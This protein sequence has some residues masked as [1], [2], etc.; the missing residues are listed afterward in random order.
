MHLCLSY[1]LPCN[2]SSP[3]HL[4]APLWFLHQSLLDVWRSSRSVHWQHSSYTS[5]Q[6][7]PYVWLPFP[8]LLF[9]PVAKH[10]EWRSPL[11][12]LVP[13]PRGLI[14]VRSRPGL[15]ATVVWT[16][17]SPVDWKSQAE[18]PSIPAQ[19]EGPQ[20]A[21]RPA[22]S[23]LK[24]VS[25][26]LLLTPFQLLLLITGCGLKLFICFCNTHW[27]SSVLDYTDLKAFLEPSLQTSIPRRVEF[28]THWWIFGFM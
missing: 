20:W 23:S 17:S 27:S 21:E 14:F 1:V 4:S 2:F 5:C 15:P 8:V 11:T 16:C 9:F 26:F 12:H 13:D 7:F 22:P 19:W 24:T 25:Y 3:W 28:S 18:G 10:G 6:L